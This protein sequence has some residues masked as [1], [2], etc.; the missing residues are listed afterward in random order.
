M[1]VAKSR[2]G[3]GLEAL[4]PVEPQQEEGKASSTVLLRLID[5]NPFQPRRE[6]DPDRLRELAQSI[7][8]HGVLQPVVLR[9]K[10]TRYQLLAGER[11]CR[12][13][14]M[15]GLEEIPALV[16]DITD[17]EM[18][19]LA[20]VENLQR[21]DLNAIEE[22]YG[23]DQLIKQLGMTQE[24]VARR[25]GRSRPHVT[26]TLRLLQ[27]PQTLQE[28]VSRE[29]IS[30]GHARAL[31]GVV[32]PALQLELAALIIDK[33]LNVRQTEELVKRTQ[34]EKQADVSRETS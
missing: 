1:R 17:A 30:A 9:R 26:N 32:D 11:R 18:M 14:N 20:I 8:L 19:E 34:A 2:L 21:E 31:V 24:E 12:A 33:G 29:T 28:F 4:I 15:V 13:A 23:Y 25:I 16:K 5:P 22:A 10:G 3:R 6:F 27:L 7:E